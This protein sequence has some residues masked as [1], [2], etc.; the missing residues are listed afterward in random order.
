MN[1]RSFFSSAFGHAALL[2]MAAVVAVNILALSQPLS[3]TQSA[4]LRNA[5]MV[6]LA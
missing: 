1:D 5:S 2:G 3:S 6:E 4:T